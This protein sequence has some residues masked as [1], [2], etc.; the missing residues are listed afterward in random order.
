MIIRQV[1]RMWKFFLFWVVQAGVG[2]AEILKIF[3][4]VVQM[5]KNLL[6]SKPNFG[7]NSVRKR[8]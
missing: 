5:G 2:W 6:D 1:C 4:I 8:A 3:E 7:L